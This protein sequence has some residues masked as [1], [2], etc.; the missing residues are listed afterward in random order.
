MSDD[1]MFDESEEGEEGG[2]EG[3]EEG[4]EGVAIPITVDITK[5][6][7]ILRFRCTAT[8]TL[9]IDAVEFLPNGTE[10]ETAYAGPTFDELDSELQDAFHEY[11]NDAGVDDTLA[12]FIGMYADYKEQQEYVKWLSGVEALVK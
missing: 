4:D 8:A 3:D 5:K 10:K 6:D 2:G 9:A 1:G 12:G 11:L 7:D